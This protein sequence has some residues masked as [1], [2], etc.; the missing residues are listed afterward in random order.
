MS[1]NASNTRFKK[2]TQKILVLTIVVTAFDP[3]HIKTLWS[4]MFSGYKVR[5]IVSSSPLVDTV[6]VY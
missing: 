6:L 1:A 2:K 3:Y 5:S 4:L